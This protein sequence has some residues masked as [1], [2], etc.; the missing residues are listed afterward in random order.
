MKLMIAIAA[1]LPSPLRG[2]VG[3]G[4]NRKL[5]VCGL[6]PTPT[7]PRKGGGRRNA[8]LELRCSCPTS[9]RLRQAE[10]FLGNEAQD[11]LRAD[12]GDARDQRLAKIT[13]DMEFLGITEAA[14]GH[15]RLLAG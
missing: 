4:G 2:G 11:Q 9:I 7:L 6:P 13:L 5:G 12:R 1:V 10:H 14:M 3:G 15:H 8:V